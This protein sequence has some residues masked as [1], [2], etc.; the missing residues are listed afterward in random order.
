[1]KIWHFPDIFWFLKIVSLKLFGNSYIYQFI[2]N[3]HALF[4]LWWK[5]H[6]LNPQKVSNYYE[7]DCLQNFILLFMSLL[8]VL[9]LKSSHIL[10]GC[11]FN[12]LKRCPRPNLK[13]LSIYLFIYLFITNIYLPQDY[14][15]NMLSCCFS[16]GSCGV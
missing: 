16:S 14:H 3:K 15:F 8:T 2:I 4:H 11:Y 13:G 1:M 10:A 6:L 5:E 7:H 9:S 12:L